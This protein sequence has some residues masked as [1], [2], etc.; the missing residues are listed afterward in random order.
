MK[1]LLKRKLV[2]GATAV[3]LLGGGAAAVAATQSSSGRQAY[4]DDVAKRLGVS[5][6]ALSSAMQAA[7][8]DRIEAAVADG[9]LTQAQANLLKQRIREGRG[10]FL[11]DTFSGGRF[12]RG[13]RERL[14]AAATKYLGITPATLRSERRAG[15]SLAQIA[16][17]TPGKSVAGLKAAILAGAKARLDGAVSDG[18]I[19]SEQARARLSALSSRIEALLE[20]TSVGPG[21]NDF[22][23]RPRGAPG[24]R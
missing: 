24:W 1:S 2:I 8:I 16:A 21:P 14:T 19:T 18:R 4:L 13:G 17:S 20:R 11:G 6:S 5:P 23:M 22:H 3:A 9:R 15:E 12:G 10:P 7:R